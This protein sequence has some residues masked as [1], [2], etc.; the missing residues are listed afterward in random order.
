M[1]YYL[2][3]AAG[4]WT[5]WLAFLDPERA[6]GRGRPIAVAAAL[7]AVLLGAGIAALQILP[8][9]EYIPFSPRA[10]G[11]PSSGWEYAVAYSFPPVEIFTAILPQFNGIHETYWGP[12]YF[13]LHS[14]YLGAVVLVLAAIG[15]RDAGR[16]RLVWG[17]TAIAVLFLLVAFGGHTPFYRLWYSL[18]PMMDKVRAPGMAFFLVAF[19]VAVFA[20][21]GAERVLDRRVTTQT[22]LIAAGIVALFALLG[23]AGVLQNVAYGLAE[24]QQAERVAMNESE[25]RAGSIRLLLFALLAMATL[26]AVAAGRLRG[27]GAAAALIVLT[28]ADLWSMDRRYVEFIAPAE[29]TF[30]TDPVIDALAAAPKPSRVLDVPFSQFGG[31]VYPGSTL[32]AYEIASV[33]GYHG[34]ELRY[35]D[36]L[37]GG[38]NVWQYVL[39]PQVLDLV[40]ARY[41]ILRMAQPLPGWHQVASTEQAAFGGPA[42]LFERDTAPAYARVLAAAAKIPEAQIVPTVLDPSFP[43]DRLVLYPDTSSAAP[44]PLGQGVPERSPVA[45]TVAEW[46]PGRIRVTLAPVPTD[47]SY[48]VVSE[49]WYPAWRADIDGNAAPVHRGNHAF[50]SVVLPPGAAEVTFTFDSAT[51]ERGRMITIAALLV[52]IA[53]LSSALWR[54]RSS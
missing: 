9:L 28:V 25:L 32:M 50:L 17:L 53:L 16:R 20:G 45:A 3:V 44:A 41:L 40:A 21:F 39:S 33:L 54:Q 47:T 19:P 6:E 49:N 24:P 12:N 26:W 46:A 5:L 52:T 14:E 2:L 23:V 51:Y 15:W 8:F 13:K 10:E 35:Y 18:M 1:T 30:R 31:P 36:E 48:L 43:V 29:I 11:G 37:M 4:L 34:N 38:K 27:Y 42:V 22:V 7:G